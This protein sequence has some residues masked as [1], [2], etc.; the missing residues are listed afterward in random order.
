MA[1]LA[2]GTP[3]F[4]RLKRPTHAI[5]GYGF[6]ASFTLLAIDLAWEYFREANG[7]PDPARFLQRI[8]AYRHVDLLHDRSAP[9]APLGC[10]LLRDAVFW[11]PERWIPW[12]EREGWSKNIVQGK[13]EQDANRASLLLAEIQHDHLTAPEELSEPT[14][15]PLEADEREFILARTRLRVGQGTFRSRLLDAYGRRCV[16]TGEHTEIV[17]DAAHI[18]PYLGPRSNHLQNGLLLTKE[19]HALFDKGYVTV[20]PELEVRVSPRLHS[21]WA[22]GRRYYPYDGTSLLDQLEGVRE[23]PAPEALEWHGRHRFLS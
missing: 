21:E 7:D 3:V 12:T 11:P 16:I 6:F 5:A 18:Q 20:T 13:R 10:T 15:V 1:D 22:N 8:G 9:R 17:L 23:R 19:F 4:F 14:F 2:P